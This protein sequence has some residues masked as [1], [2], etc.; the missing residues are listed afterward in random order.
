MDELKQVSDLTEPSFW[1]VEAR[2]I[3]R[4]IVY[5]SGP[6]NS[7]KTY[8]ALQS[9]LTSSSGIYC[10][11]LKLLANEVYIKANNAQTKCD[12]L[13][14]EERKFADAQGVP[15][16][17]IAC[18]VEMANLDK[19]YEVAVIDEIQ[20]IKDAQRGWAWTR[21]LL[22]LKVHFNYFILHTL[23]NK[24]VKKIQKIKRP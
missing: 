21:A 5:H 8:A 11:P 23:N 15:A 22:G 3:K 13:T 4:K 1:Y 14:G 17:H 16:E 18:T 7:G 10:G 6:T 2:E 24:L 20:M 9:F 12:L 19:D